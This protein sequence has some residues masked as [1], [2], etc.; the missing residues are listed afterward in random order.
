MKA[1]SQTVTKGFRLPAVSQIPG[2]LCLPAIQLLQPP[3][4]CGEVVLQAEPPRRRR[5][6]LLGGPNLL[7]FL[8]VKRLSSF[9]SIMASEQLRE[10]IFQYKAELEDLTSNV[11]VAINTLSQLADEWKEQAAP[12]I[13][14]LVEKRLLN[15]SGLQLFSMMSLAGQLG[16]LPPQYTHPRR[17]T[18][19]VMSS[20]IPSTSYLLCICWTAS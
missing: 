11:K 2:Q 13:A 4:F 12:S 17:L 18:V 3:H 16:L 6:Q 7:A 15:V 20:V 14:A 8:P 9:A 5:Q 1:H 19:R 10:F